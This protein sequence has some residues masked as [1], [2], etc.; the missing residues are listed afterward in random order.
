MSRAPRVTAAVCAAALALLLSACTGPVPDPTPSPTPSPTGDAVPAPTTTPGPGSEPIVDPV[1]SL[2]DV[3]RM[4]ARPEALE[5]VDANGE[6]VRALPYA[7][8]PGEAIA[9]LTEI[10][11]AA[12]VDTTHAR[13]THNLATVAHAWDDVL[14]LNE[15]EFEEEDL[16]WRTEHTAN[17]SISFGAARV[18]GI[19]LTTSAGVSVGDDWASVAAGL[20]PDDWTCS[21]LAVEHLEISEPVRGPHKVGVGISANVPRTPELSDQVT[22]VYAPVPVAE[23]C[24]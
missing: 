4:V 9:V 13:G 21:G 14:L 10:V 22:F 11:G 18:R 19:P 2:G 17:F 15:F 6:V 24:A 1:V 7:G 5:L 23:G 12:P 3:T 20:D 8:S 16:S